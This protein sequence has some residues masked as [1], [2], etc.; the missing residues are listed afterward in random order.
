M[1]KF[2]K[3]WSKLAPTVIALFMALSASAG[4]FITGTIS[5]F[6]FWTLLGLSQIISLLTT[7]SDAIEEAEET[8]TENTQIN[9]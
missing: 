9:S 2:F 5:L 4:H 7:F 8:K 3:S 1:K 6:E